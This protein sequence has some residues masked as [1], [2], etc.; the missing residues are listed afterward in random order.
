MG[1]KYSFWTIDPDNPNGP[2]KEVILSPSLALRYFKSDIV[3]Y[4]NLCAVDEVFKDPLRIFSKIR[5]HSDGGWCYIGRPKTWYVSENVTSQPFPSN[6][7]YAVYINDRMVLQGHRAELV[8]RED[9]DSPNGY[10]FRFGVLKWKKGT[11]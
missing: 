10:K 2:K 3:R 9:K 11:S 6:L 7:V 5:I 8:D 1:K 4:Q